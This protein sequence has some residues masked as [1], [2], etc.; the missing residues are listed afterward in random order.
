ML[1]LAASRTKSK[2][3]SAEAELKTFDEVTDSPSS[4]PPAPVAAMLEVGGPQST[5][6]NTGARAGHQC[7]VRLS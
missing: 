5:I 6:T 7:N 4:P 2:S 1:A 3:V